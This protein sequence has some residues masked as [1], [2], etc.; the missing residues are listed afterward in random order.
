M[1]TSQLI[2]NNHH[3]ALE[4]NEDDQRDNATPYV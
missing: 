3:A 4:E 2:D 1:G